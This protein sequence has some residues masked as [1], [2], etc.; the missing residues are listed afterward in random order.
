M[1]NFNDKKWPSSPLKAK[2]LVPEQLKDFLRI[3]ADYEKSAFVSEGHLEVRA[4]GAKEFT[5]PI[6]P[7][8][9]GITALLPHPNGHLYGATSGSNSHLFFYNPAPDAD[10]VADIGIVAP[11]S[12][13]T[14]LLLLTLGEEHG[15]IVGLVNKNGGGASLFVY[16][17]CE[18]LLKEKDF[19]GM[20]VR[21]IFDLAAEDQLF[22]SCIDPCHSA[23]KISHLKDP[24]FDEPIADMT[25]STDEDRLIL[26]GAESG[27]LYSCKLTSKEVSRIGCLDVN[28]NFSPKLVSDQNGIIYG[29]GLYGKL[30]ACNPDEGWVKPTGCKAPSLKGRELYNRV[31]AWSV[32]TRRNI[33]YGGTVDGIIF[34][35]FPE[36][37]RVAC[38]GKPID[39]GNVR[40]MTIS[41]NRVYSLI[42][43]EGSCCHLT[44]FDRDSRELRDLGCLLARSE[45]PW[46]GYEF[47]SMTTGKNGTVFMGENDRISQLFMYFPPVF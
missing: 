10:A 42:G 7:G 11:D 38:L 27:T 20:G 17:P 22:F 32:D 30:F 6:P 12:T 25:L 45:R 47:A 1:L 24:Q 18:L 5:K 39:Q 16:K 8:E 2:N 44:C 41:G 35:F 4:L 19:T 15:E 31:T 46:N 34:Q 9:S 3:R 33:L 21:E 29:A 28:G 43:E 13:I 37:N 36:E 26:L 23:G 14:K 40:A